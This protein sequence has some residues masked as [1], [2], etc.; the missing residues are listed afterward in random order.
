[1]A[2]MR[3]DTIKFLTLQETTR[4]FHRLA[5]YRR[6]RVEPLAPDVRPGKDGPTNARLKLLAGILRVGFD[7]LKQR[8]HERWIRKFPNH[9]VANQ[10]C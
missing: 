9:R 8:E 6:E 2:S 7:T 4:L 5:S 3:T 10:N 1:M